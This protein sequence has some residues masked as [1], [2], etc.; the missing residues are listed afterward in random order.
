[1]CLSY[2]NDLRPL[3]VV[4]RCVAVVKIVGIMKVLTRLMVW[5]ALRFRSQYAV[6]Y[7]E[8]ESFG[9]PEA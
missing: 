7:V 6:A 9:D 3:S 1:M 5:V 4:R 2:F 8:A